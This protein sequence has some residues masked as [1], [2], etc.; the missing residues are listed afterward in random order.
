MALTLDFQRGL[1]RLGT[2]SPER[3]AIPNTGGLVRGMARGT[4]QQRLG[5]MQSGLADRRMDAAVTDARRELRMARKDAGLALGAT[6][7]NT[8][9]TL[10]QN[11]EREIAQQEAEARASQERDMWDSMNEIMSRFGPQILERLRI[12]TNPMSNAR[13]A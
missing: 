7:V 4:M 9:L 6:A 10:A 12:D 8:G 1:S 3:G 2:L 13:E 11:R 5:D